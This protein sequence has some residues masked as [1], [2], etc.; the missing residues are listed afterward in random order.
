MELIP[1]ILPYL[2]AALIGYALGKL[3]RRLWVR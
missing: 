3:T 1:V 2:I